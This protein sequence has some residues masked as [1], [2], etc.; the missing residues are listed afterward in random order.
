MTDQ[1]VGPPVTAQPVGLPESIVLSPVSNDPEARTPRVVWNPAASDEPVAGEHEKP[2]WMPLLRDGI[3]PLLLVGDL[4]GCLLAAVVTHTSLRQAAGF[5]VILVA[6]MALGGAYR[7]RL[8]LSVLDDVPRIVQAWL[9]AVA[10][11]IVG[12][13]LIGKAAL[14]DFE[15]VF[16]AGLAVLA[17]R[18]LNYAAVRSL[19]ARGF[20]SHPT[21]VVG[22]DSTGRDVANQLI[23]HPDCGLSP[24]GFLDQH[25]EER[26]PLPAPVLGGPAQLIPILERYSPRALIIARSQLS[27]TELVA[28]IRGCH[29][30]HCELFVLPRLYEVTQVGQ[31]MDFLGDM[32]L[33]RLRRAAYRSWQWRCKRVI[34]AVLSAI[35][36]IIL[37]PVLAAV[38]L[39]VRLEG[40]PGVIFR[41]ERVGVDGRR[42][43]IMKFRSMR[44][45]N[46]DE[47]RTNWNI[48][49]DDR[50][51][52]VG[53]LI[54][55]LS[56]DELPQLVNILRGDMSLVGPRPE[57]PHFVAEFDRLYGGYAARHRVPS[58]LTGWAQVHGSRGDTDIAERARY[59]NFY[60]ENWSLWLDLKI[61][62]L[63]VVSVF[64]SPGA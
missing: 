20:V 59:D 33:V 21:V 61:M 31:D 57:R 19:R 35:A 36:L 23:R 8:A 1:P 17:F 63:T 49:H 51:G 39:A 44:P 53:R 25:V 42:I 27:E 2:F 62:L 9:M 5:A 3:R 45:V 15:V 11:F 32:P 30:Y 22:C 56:L 46:E 52:P 34:D 7:S 10:V 54:R 6:L 14:E 40:G 29:R 16:M 38:A 24:I 13:Q 37:S 28:M 4:A 26:V 12:S 48:A 60:I 58:G 41:Q 18:T 55:K 47:S 43:V 64:K 50:V